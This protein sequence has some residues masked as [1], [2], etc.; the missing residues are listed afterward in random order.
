MNRSGMWLG[1][2]AAATYSDETEKIEEGDLIILYTDGVSEAENPR[3]E[4]FGEEGLKSV[5]S[6]TPGETPHRSV[7]TGDPGRAGFYGHQRA[8]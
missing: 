8:E 5:I 3:G 4:S 7:Q 1:V 6:K 2:D